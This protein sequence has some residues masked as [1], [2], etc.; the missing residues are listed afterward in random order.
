MTRTP[1][2]ELLAS[3]AIDSLLVGSRPETVRDMLE[4]LIYEL[5]SPCRF[6]IT[7]HP[8]IDSDLY[9]GFITISPVS[10]T[11][12]LTWDAALDAIDPKTRRRG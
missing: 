7:S 6:A 10:K 9:W 3:R 1:E 12:E 8:H 5:R 4:Q 2:H 11:R